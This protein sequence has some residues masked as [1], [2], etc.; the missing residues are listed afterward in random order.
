MKKKHIKAAAA[1]L[2]AVLVLVPQSVLAAKTEEQIILQE[3]TD[4]YQA[5]APEYRFDNNARVQKPS[6]VSVRFESAAP[7]PVPW[8]DRPHAC[9]LIRKRR[10]FTVCPCR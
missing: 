9:C 7:S 3:K 4:L 5:A 6:S 2:A 8:T 10:A 1:V